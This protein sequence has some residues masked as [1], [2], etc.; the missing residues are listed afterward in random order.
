MAGVCT[1]V[2]GGGGVQGYPPKAI[3]P[4]P[5]QE[6]SQPN[7]KLLQIIRVM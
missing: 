4:R 6:F 1:G 5:S 2:G 7:Y 3:P